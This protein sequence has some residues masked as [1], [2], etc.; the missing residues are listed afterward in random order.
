MEVINTS[1]FEAFLNEQL[2]EPHH[3]TD[4]YLERLI[5]HW[6]ET[7]ETSFTLPPEDTKSG[8]GASITFTAERRYFIREGGRDVPV[9]DLSEGYDVYYPVLVFHDSGSASP[10][11]AKKDAPAQTLLNPLALLRHKSGRSLKALALISGVGEEK[12]ARYEQPN[13]DMR[14]IPLGEASD[15]TKAL[16]VHAEA[17]LTCAP[18]AP[19]TL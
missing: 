1:Y 18:A 4:A 5:I 9:E 7:G 6:G 11:A 3:D 12:L 8:T 2:A 15:I 17:L 10:A 13:Y 14:S 16:N 19:R